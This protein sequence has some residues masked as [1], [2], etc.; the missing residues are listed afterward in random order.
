MKT[1]V[2]IKAEHILEVQKSYSTYYSCL[3]KIDASKITKDI[4]STSK[5]H[6]QIKIIQRYQKESIQ[7]KKILEI[8]SGYG[9]FVAVGVIDYNADVYGVEPSALGFGG[10]FEMAQKILVSN[11][12]EQSRIVCAVAE[13]LPFE[14]NFFDIVYSTNVFEHVNDPEKAFSEAIRVCKPGGLIQIVIPNYGSFYE[15][16]YAC[17]YIPYTP[18][19]L[20]KLWLKYVLKR[21]PSYADTL[22]TNLNYF[23]VQRYLKPFKDAN[24]I[25]VLSMGEE[26]FFERMNTGDFVPYVGLTKVQH[27]LSLLKKCKLVWLISKILMVVKSHSPLIVTIRKKN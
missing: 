15:G 19:K 26:I 12:L 7:N 14:D 16:H 20:W 8:G 9:L 27:A 23:S 24:V 10:S 3:G 18:K 1:K 11:N 25:A 6:D 2:S 4:L 22:R 5:V 17:W 21:D 13:D